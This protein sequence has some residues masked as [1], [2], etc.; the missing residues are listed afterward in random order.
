MKKKTTWATT[1]EVLDV[2][3]GD[4]F[5]ARLDLGWKISLVTMV[6]VRG[7]NAPELNEEGGAAAR[8]YLAEMLP[9]GSVV[10][11]ESKRLDK[12]GR[13]E[14]SV[15]LPTRGNLADRL[16]AAGFVKKVG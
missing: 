7:I 2:Y 4:T 6:R 15:T 12:Y 14:A 13:S 10:H 1:A 9:V 11:I 3:D 5:R 16:I 8:D